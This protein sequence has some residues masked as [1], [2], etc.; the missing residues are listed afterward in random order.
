MVQAIPTGAIRPRL[1]LDAPVRRLSVSQA[2]PAQ[3]AA[4][5]VRLLVY[6]GVVLLAALG[7][8]TLLSVTASTLAAAVSLVVGLTMLAA[9]PTAAMGLLRRLQPRE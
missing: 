5:G 4:V 3:S 6:V 9:A 7:A 2:T 8:G 1:P